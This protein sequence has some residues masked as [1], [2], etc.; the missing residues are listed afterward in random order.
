MAALTVGLYGAG[1]GASRDL[2]VKAD[3]TSS[4]PFRDGD[5]ASTFTGGDDDG[6]LTGGDRNGMQPDVIL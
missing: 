6:T 3:L 1:F 2:A 4:G 5:A